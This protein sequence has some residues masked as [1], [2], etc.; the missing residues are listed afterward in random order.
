MNGIGWAISVLPHL[1]KPTTPQAEPGALTSADFWAFD[2]MRRAP[3]HQ[4]LPAVP[5]K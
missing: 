1:G 2:S 3:W 5:P 4:T